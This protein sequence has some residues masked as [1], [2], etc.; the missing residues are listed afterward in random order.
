MARAPQCT[1][2]TARPLPYVPTPDAGLPEAVS[3]ILLHFPIHIPLAI[4]SIITTADDLESSGLAPQAAQLY[5]HYY[6][7]RKNGINITMGL[8]IACEWRS[9]YDARFRKSGEE[10]SER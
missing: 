10:K 2:I 6:H 9:T 4:L 5:D 3:S 1:P 8:N 7:Q